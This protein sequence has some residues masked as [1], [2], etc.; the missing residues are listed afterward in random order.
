M[1]PSAVHGTALNVFHAC[2]RRQA[3]RSAGTVRASRG[4]GIGEVLLYD[5]AKDEVYIH[6]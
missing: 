2:K 4:G 3:L 1:W 6:V 5:E